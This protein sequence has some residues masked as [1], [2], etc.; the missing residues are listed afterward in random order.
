MGVF[1]LLL[2]MLSVRIF[3]PKL[4][5]VRKLQSRKLELKE[6]VTRLEERIKELKENQEKFSSDPD[7]VVRTAH[8]IGMVKTNETVF[9][10]TDGKTEEPDQE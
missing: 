10:F 2:I 8:E 9:K 5:E 7:F 1:C 6:E 4:S 3:M